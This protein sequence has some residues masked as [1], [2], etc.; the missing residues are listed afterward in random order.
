MRKGVEEEV[1]AEREEEDVG[2][3]R[4]DEVEGERRRRGRRLRR[5]AVDIFVGNRGWWV[6]GEM[7]EWIEK[8][9]RRVGGG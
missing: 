6:G 5:A 8:C 7:K 3:G 4:A 9:L 2:V 1:G